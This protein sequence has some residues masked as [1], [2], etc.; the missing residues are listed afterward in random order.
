MGQHPSLIADM[1]RPRLPYLSHETTRH[2]RKVWYFKKD[3]KRL[4]LPDKYGSPEFKAAYDAALSGLP[5]ENQ[6]TSSGTLAWLIGEY[7]KSRQFRELSPSTQRMRD[8]IMLAVI[9]KNDGRAGKIP[10]SHIRAKHIEAGMEDRATTPHAANNYRKTMSQLFTWAVD[11][12]KLMKVNPVEGVGRAKAET[13]GF[14]TWTVEQVEQ[15]RAHHAIGTKP[16]LAIELLLF[17]GLRRSDVIHAG[18]QHVKDGVLSMR[19]QKTGAWVHIPIF[20]K[21]QD[22]I[23]AT[24]TGDLAFLVTESGKPFSSAASFGNWFAKQCKEA[25]LPDECRAHGLRKAGATIAADEGATPHELMAMFGWT[26]VAMAEVYT[27]EADKKRLARSA[28][29]RLAGKM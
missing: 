14:H 18:K 21:L 20:A 1:P 19:T 17:L 4:R 27:K 12:A 9:N 6:R 7:K 10:S 16:R 24:T 23:D 28:A 3:G 26:R 5:V 2:G 15:Y 29:A 13:D 8:N 11:V 25:K 22:A